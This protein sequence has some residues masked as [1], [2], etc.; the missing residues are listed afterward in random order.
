MAHFAKI[1]SFGVVE[2]V[3]VVRN[4]DILDENGQESEEVGKR[5]LESIGL[6]GTWF[7]TSYNASF[8]GAFAGVGMYYDLV[9]DVFTYEKPALPE[10]PI[11]E[12]TTPTE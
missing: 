12:V 11:V 1:N 4:E 9:N 10:G 5:F 6:Y 7:Q 3:V 2:E 8:R